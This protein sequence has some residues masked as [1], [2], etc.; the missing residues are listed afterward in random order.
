MKNVTA[1]LL[2]ESGV[3]VLKNNTRLSATKDHIN[4]QKILERIKE[5]NFNNIEQLFKIKATFEKLFN[6][7]IKNGR[8]VYY[9]NK[10]LHNSLTSRILT[11]VRDGL[12]YRSWVCF[13]D[14]LMENPSEY[15]RNQLFSYVEL[16]GLP[17]DNDGFVYAWKAVNKD[18]WDKYTGNTHQYKVGKIIKMDRNKCDKD[19]KVAC[20]K[21]LHS[22]ETSYVVGYGDNNDD[23]FVL[24]RFSP[25]DVM[26]CPADSSWRKL[27]LCKLRVMREVK[28]EDVLPLKDKFMGK[29][30]KD[31]K[32]NHYEQKRD[33]NGKF[34]SKN[35]VAP[36]W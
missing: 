35:L 12:P 13:L 22:G 11:Y 15:C 1:A 10:R 30:K 28:K 14:K 34:I 33:A 9:K 23:R 16:Y 6:V 36:P 19:A 18:L 8:E 21:G 31:T 3:M 7:T 27:R 24:I 32:M 5:N 4:Y 29:I 26:S 17:I 2:T 20:G 25:K